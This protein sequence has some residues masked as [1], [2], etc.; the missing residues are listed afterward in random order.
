MEHQLPK[1]KVA[2]RRQQTDANLK[3]NFRPKISPLTLS[4]RDFTWSVC[5]VSSRSDVCFALTAISRHPVCSPGPSGS[6]ALW[7]RCPAEVSTREASL[8]LGTIGILLRPGIAG[9]HGH[10]DSVYRRLC[11]PSAVISCCPG[12]QMSWPGLR[13]KGLCLWKELSLVRG[14][15]DESQR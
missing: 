5:S 14:L 8:V 15:E 4:M 6:V 11:T 9:A 13:G 1:V 2:I 12:P 3:K 10:V 7:G